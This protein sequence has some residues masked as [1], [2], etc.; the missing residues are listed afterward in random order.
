MKNRLLKRDLNNSLNFSNHFDSFQS[1]G[2]FFPWKI[3]F[4]LVKIFFIAYLLLNYVFLVSIETK[5]HYCFPSQFNRSIRD[6][7]L[8]HSHH[9][10]EGIGL[11]WKMTFEIFIKSLRFETPWVRKNGFYESVCLSVVGRVRH[12]SR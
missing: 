12:N 2:S 10:W 5:Y 11:M 9:G 7:N 4:K 6:T 8:L 1:K 3:F